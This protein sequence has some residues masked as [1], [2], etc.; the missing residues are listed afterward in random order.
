VNNQAYQLRPGLFVRAAVNYQRIEDAVLLPRAA[1]L[2]DTNAAHVFVVESGKAYKRRIALGLADGERVQVV[3]GLDA[4]AQVVVVGQ[5][6]LI[7]GSEVEPV[8]AAV[9]AVA[10]KTT[11]SL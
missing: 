5:A 1:L 2:G 3:E 7:D 6:A 4:G 9:A 10:S 11:A 8:G